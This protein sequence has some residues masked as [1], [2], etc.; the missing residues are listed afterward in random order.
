MRAQIFTASSAAILS[1]ALSVSCAYAG[2]TSNEGGPA[3]GTQF[4]SSPNGTERCTCRT[5]FARWRTGHP[6]CEARQR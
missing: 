5:N 1:L 4:Q 3:G 2:A 6:G